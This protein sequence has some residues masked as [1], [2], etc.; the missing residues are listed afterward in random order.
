MPMSSSI[1]WAERVLRVHIA[2]RELGCSTRTVIRMIQ[3]GEIC[4]IR[5]GR[6]AWGIRACDLYGCGR[7][8]NDRN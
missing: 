2:A 7:G 8:R 1:R 4:A 3:R 6:R 5:I